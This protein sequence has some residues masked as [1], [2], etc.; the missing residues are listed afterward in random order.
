MTEESETTYG[1]TFG[2]P[3]A[4]DA[5]RKLLRSEG[6]G[7]TAMVLEELNGLL[8]RVVSQRV[9][10]ADLER[11]G[12]RDFFHGKEH[13]QCPAFSDQAREPLR[14]TPA[15]DES[16]RRSAMTED[17]IWRGDATMTS[18]CKI[19]SSTHAVAA[20]DSDHW[21]RKVLNR[22]HQALADLGEFVSFG[23]GESGDLIQ[24]GTGGEELVISG[25]DETPCIA[26][27]FAY[28][29]GQGSHAGSGQT[30][31]AVGAL[32]AQHTA[33]IELFSVK[34]SRDHFREGAMIQPD[35]QPE[36]MA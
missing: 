23:P 1:I 26:G 24:V 14:A 33:M 22:I 2:Y 30:I 16:E 18:K 31:G 34:E 13:L 5:R 10:Q 17:G 19:Q 12:G 32:Q 20:D 8:Y 15:G 29:A 25:N 36:M 27:K 28:C 4:I 35:R 11:F 6:A 3:R 7:Q 21:S 9:Y